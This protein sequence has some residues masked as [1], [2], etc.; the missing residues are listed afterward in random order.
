[1]SPPITYRMSLPLDDGDGDQEHQT[2]DYEGLRALEHY[3][4]RGGRRWE[5]VNLKAVGKDL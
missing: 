2:G 3:R 1:M 5:G 4:W